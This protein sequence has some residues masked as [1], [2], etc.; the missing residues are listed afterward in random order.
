MSLTTAELVTCID[1]SKLPQNDADVMR[2]LYKGSEESYETLADQAQL[3]HIQYPVLQAVGNRLS[4]PYYLP[5]G[6][7][8][9]KRNLHQQGTLPYQKDTADPPVR[10]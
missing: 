6:L 2:Q 4:L 1:R 8:Y 5:K 3:C 10:F 9:G 7:P